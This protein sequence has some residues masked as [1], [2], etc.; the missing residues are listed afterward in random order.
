[1][2]LQKK[3]KGGQT[4]VEWALILPVLLFIIIMVFDFGRAMFHYSVVYNAARE[5]A[6][7][8]IIFPCDDTEIKDA[9]K[10][11]V[12]GLV[13]TND[14]ITV[15]KDR[16][17]DISKHVYSRIITVTVTSDFSPVTPMVTAVVGSNITIN[18]SSTMRVEK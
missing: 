1:M 7:Y 4:L 15:T 18:S 3:T 10:E 6:R 12:V 13:I 9:A 8:G 16:A 11:K 17:C 2:D 5:G 14:Q